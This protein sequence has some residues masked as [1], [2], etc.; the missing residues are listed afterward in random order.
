MF[1]I[2]EAIHRALKT[3]STFAF[4]LVI[5][6]VFAVGGGILGW[7]VDAGYKNS[8]DYKKEHTPV[9]GRLQEWQ[10]T[11]L[12]T[13]FSQ[14]PGHKV[15]ILAGVGDETAAYANQFKDLFQ[16]SGWI[17]DGPKRAPIN[18]VVFDVQLSRDQYIETH[19]EVPIIVSTFVSARIR[20]RPGTHD[21][22]IPSDWL[23]LWVGAKA[24]DGEPD[25]IPLQVPPGTFPT[26]HPAP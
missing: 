13:T 18:Q 21:P 16:K 11:I 5:A 15:L 22:G 14:Y 6:G 26:P 20:H 19:P 23:V 12:L 1:E 17:V 7:L 4:V 24:P 10:Q 2:V 8:A 25:H 3:E 9:P